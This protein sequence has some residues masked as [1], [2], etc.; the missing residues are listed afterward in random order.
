M[1]KDKNYL[2]NQFIEN[3]KTVKSIAEECNVSI[4]T[5]EYY[6][7][8]YNLKRGNIKHTINCDAVDAT[9]PVFNY[10]AGLIATDGYLDKRIPRVSLRC[11][12]LG[13][14]SVLGRLK[15]YFGFTGDIKLY[16]DLFDLTITSRYLIQMLNGM[17]VSSKGK[18][19][20]KFP[21]HFYDENCAR[22]YL[23]G[24]L[25]GDGN[26]T[27]ARTFRITLSNKK[28]LLD[29]S[30]YL[31]NRLGINTEVKPDRK[32]WKVEMRKE[33]SAIFLDWVYTGFDEFKFID[34]YYRYSG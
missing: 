7:G 28:F 25:D 15:H 31:N 32:Y 3:R 26:I 5:I 22:M 2:K 18:P 11:K 17:G 33:A 34:K 12:N 30:N 13:C 8:K 24:I 16:R 21:S 1:Y 23:R 6:L 9:S 14:D 19:Y 4:S 29:M 27:V 20:N 10:Y